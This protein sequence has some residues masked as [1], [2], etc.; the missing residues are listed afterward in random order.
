MHRMC[1][2]ISQVEAPLWARPVSGIPSISTGRAQA[3]DHCAQDIHMVVHRKPVAAQ[4]PPRSA[5][6][7]SGRAGTARAT[8]RHP[9]LRASTPMPWR[10]LPGA[11]AAAPIASG[12]R[13]NRPGISPSPGGDPDHHGWQPGVSPTS[14]PPGANAFRPGRIRQGPSMYEMEGPCPASPRQAGRLA[15]LALRAACRCQ[16]PV[17][18]TGRPVPPASRGSPPGG[19]RFQR[20]K[21]FY[22]LRQ[23]GRKGPR[24]VISGFFR[25]PHS[26]HSIRAVIRFCRRLSTS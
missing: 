3:R 2:T 26:I 5:P 8:A 25:C 10:R 22:C 19:A 11:A 16:A 6:G 4:W 24:P 9:V 15:L 21:Y 18:G 12:S 14:R 23:R 13:H 20:R 7:R 17:R 1:I